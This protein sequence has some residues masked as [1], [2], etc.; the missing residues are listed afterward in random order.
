MYVS[1]MMSDSTPMQDENRCIGGLNVALAKRTRQSPIKRSTSETSSC[2]QSQN[3]EDFIFWNDIYLKYKVKRSRKN[4]K[5]LKNLCFQKITH[6]SLDGNT[7]SLDRV[8]NE[9][10]DSMLE[11]LKANNLRVPEQLARQLLHADSTWMDFGLVQRGLDQM[12][13]WQHLICNCP[14]ISVLVWR[15][16]HGKPYT[17]LPIPDMLNYLPLLEHIEMPDFW[18]DI[19]ALTI[20]AEQYSQQLRVLH[21]SLLKMNRDELQMLSQLKCLRVLDFHG[22]R[23]PPSDLKRDREVMSELLKELPYLEVLWPS[24]P[25]TCVQSGSLE[26]LWNHIQIQINLKHLRIGDRLNYWPQLV[27]EVEHL[28]ICG[29]PRK[30]TIHYVKSL[31]KLRSLNVKTTSLSCQTWLRQMLESVGPQLTELVVEILLEVDYDVHLSFSCII[32][33]CPNLEKLHISGR[34]TTLQASEIMNHVNVNNYRGL[35]VVKMDLSGTFFQSQVLNDVITFA[36]DLEVLR[37]GP[38]SELKGTGFL[39]KILFRACNKPR[40]FDRLREIWITLGHPKVSAELCQVL[41]R[42]AFCAPELNKIYINAHM[43]DS[44]AYF[45]QLQLFFQHFMPQIDLLIY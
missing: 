30:D 29:Q 44:S 27:T 17:L 12:L 45:S 37:V 38:L 14:F 42:V 20:L 28:Y 3:E 9:L 15:D 2:Q 22:S 26:L 18:C 35:K 5:T 16:Y 39:E 6:L 41:R 43:Q 13:V 11:Y 25:E 1:E 23:L 34:V 33:M 24:Y 36:D 10:K 7:I 19:Q 31:Q 8:E 40:G 4:L 21:V 32:S